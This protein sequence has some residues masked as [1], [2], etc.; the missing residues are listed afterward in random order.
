VDIGPTLAS[1]LGVKPDMPLD[2]V[3]LTEIV[4]PR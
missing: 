3:P 1:L 4:G 2:G